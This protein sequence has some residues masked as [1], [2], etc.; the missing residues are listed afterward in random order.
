MQVSKNKILFFL[1]FFIQLNIY[2]V[3]N[4]S[5]SE[6][7]RVEHK[8]DSLLKVVDYLVYEDDDLNLQ[9]LKKAESLALKSS[10]DKKLGDVY[11]AFGVYYYIRGVYDLSLE[12]HL[13]ALKIHEKHNNFSK[14]SKSLNGFGLVQ[15]ELNQ[16]DEAISTFKECIVY[17][18]KLKRFA[19]VGRNYF[20]IALVEIENKNHQKV[21]ENLKT[22]LDY[23]QKY[24]DYKTEHMVYNRLGDAK[25]MLKDLDSSIYFYQKVLRHKQGSSLWEKVYSYTGLA[26]VYHQKANYDKAIEYGLNSLELAKKI[27]TKWDIVRS[28]TT[29]ADIYAAKQEMNNAYK[30]LKEASIYN[31]SL[32]NENKINE[33]N[34]LQLKRKEA[35]NSRLKNSNTLAL[36]REKSD[37]IITYSFGILIV[38]LVG[39]LFLLVKNLKTKERFNQELQQ[40]NDDI[41]NQKA[42]IDF[43]REALEGLNKSK[44]KLFSILSH[45]LKTPI[46]SIYQ[47]LELH[48]QGEM[49][50]EFQE[51]IFE[52]LHKQVQGTSR[53]LNNL[54]FWAS[55]QMDG[56]VVNLEKINLTE[57]SAVAIDSL[58]MEAFKK[59]ITIKHFNEDIRFI[60]ADIGQARII[61]QNILA[62]AIKFTPVEGVIEVFYSQDENFKNLHILDYGE[63]IDENV[64]NDII[65]Y[66]KRM[67]SELG[68]A[69]EEGTGLGLLLV[70]QFLVN[71][72]GKM[73]VKSQKGKGTEFIIS[74]LKAK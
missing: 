43:Q 58:Y 55:T 48:Q 25:L 15:L 54:L 72:K 27:D 5:V 66:D 29:L 60:Y 41:Q 46:N 53:M 22:S 1:L 36:E 24:R 68:T 3:D 4:E 10:N 37:R 19:A 6:T 32:L 64:I 35:E 13:K 9:M 42:I 33:I 39:I 67:A 26:Q 14:Y 47:I 2:A 28:A 34:Y 11:T 20:N 69:M 16:L 44:N 23:A 50:P 51:E 52:Q 21:L 40:K 7:A 45:D 31:D 57:V 62:N 65:N 30:Y 17:N 38:F 63:G 73:D 12:M 71:N 49:T 74:F 18:T 8:I 61:V 59:K 56:I 70:K